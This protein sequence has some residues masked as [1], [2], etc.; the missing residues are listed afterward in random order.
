[1]VQIKMKV[2]DYFRNLISKSQNTSEL[3]RII[4]NAFIISNSI[5]VTSSTKIVS[6]LN[7][8]DLD[9]TLSILT[10]ISNEGLTFSLDDLIQ[11]FE[12]LVPSCE[13]KDKGVVYTPVS[14]L[15]TLLKTLLGTKNSPRFAILHVD[16]EF[17]L[18]SQLNK[19]HN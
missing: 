8:V 14:I 5:N 4:V 11:V 6:Y 13:R 15:N 7:Q 9:S 17:S 12:I 1:M 16:V 19:F 3:E 2:F 18:L 10:E